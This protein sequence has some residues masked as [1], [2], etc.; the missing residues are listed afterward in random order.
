MSSSSRVFSNMFPMFLGIYIGRWTNPVVGIFFSSLAIKFLTIGLAKFP[1]DSSI[2]QLIS[3]SLFLL[4]L[5]F[6]NNEKRVRLWKKKKQRVK[7][8]K[9]VYA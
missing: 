7:E 8:V 2:Q 1:M 5:V 9:G 4:F 3:A 6:Q